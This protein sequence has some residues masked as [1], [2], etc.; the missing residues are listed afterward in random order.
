MRLVAVD[1]S[2]HGVFRPGARVAEVCRRHDISSA[3]IYTWRR[4]LRE[5][6]AEPAPEDLPAPDFAAAVMIE[7]VEPAHP[8]AQPAIIIDLARGKRISIFASAS[9]A[10]VASALKAL[11]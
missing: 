9:P 7:G 11:R 1:G 10:L 2:D 6:H 8:G 5:A 3:L 4:K